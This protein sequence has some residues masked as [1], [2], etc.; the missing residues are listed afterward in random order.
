MQEIHIL[1][2]LRARKLAAKGILYLGVGISGGE[3]GARHGPSIMPGGPQEAYERIRPVFEATAAKVN[4]VPCV[5]YLG[6]GSAGHF[7]KMVHN[8]IEYSIMQLISETYDLM[9]Q[10]LDFNDDQLH[11][12]YNE[13]NNGELSSYLLEITSHIFRKVDQKTGNRLVDEIYRQSRC[14]I[15]KRL[16]LL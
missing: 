16:L 5:T 8:G 13:W 2:I 14:V 4:D 9:K 1:R 3:E 10:G 11:D 12:V 15:G 6:P 7:V